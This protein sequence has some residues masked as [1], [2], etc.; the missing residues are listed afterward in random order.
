MPLFPDH[1]DQANSNLRFL[2]HLNESSK[3]SEFFDWKVTVCFYSSLHIINAY[4]AEKGLHYRTHIDVRNNINPENQTSISRIDEEYYLAY[5]KLEQLS[6][7]ARYLVNQGNSDSS[8]ASHTYSKHYAKALRHL[9][10]MIKFGVTFEARFFKPVVVC[11]EMK[12]KQHLTYL[13]FK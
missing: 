6:R 8:K 13:A 3:E 2:N 11:Q 5:L 10:T 12:D 9:N 7:R 1:I 4:L